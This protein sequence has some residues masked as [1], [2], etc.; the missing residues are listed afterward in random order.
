MATCVESINLGGSVESAEANNNYSFDVTDTK[1][2]LFL[3]SLDSDQ[4]VYIRP[5]IISTL[6]TNAVVFISIIKKSDASTIR[7]T[8]ITGETI[9]STDLQEGSYYICFRTLFGS[10]VVGSS[11]DYVKFKREVE[12]SAKFYTGENGSFDL[13]RK[14]P[15]FACTRPLKYTL[16][17]GSLP[18]GLVMDTSGRI[19]GTLPLIDKENLKDFPSYSLYHGDGIFYTPI[20]VR[21]EFLVKLE[22]LDNNT[23][24][25]YRKFCIMIVNDWDLTTPILEMSEMDY[26]GGEVEYDTGYTNLPKNLC[27]PCETKGKKGDVRYIYDNNGYLVNVEKIMDTPEFKNSLYTWQV[28]EFG[29]ITSGDYTSKTELVN[30]IESLRYVIDEFEL[31]GDDFDFD[32][33]IVLPENYRIHRNESLLIP[34]DVPTSKAREWVM[35]NLNDIIEDGYGEDILTGYINKDDNVKVEIVSRG[36]D[37][38]LDLSF[39][40]DNESDISVQYDMQREL[41]L[42]KEPM[43]VKTDFLP[44]ELTAVISYESYN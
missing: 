7:N 38:Y 1:N 36:T 34:S 40:D 23:K 35:I 16:I 8:K 37:N 2:K 21:Y 42:A 12:I 11:F 25:V 5:K 28:N 41:I 15:V 13:Q 19:H 14:L 4:T 6:T 10:H 18:S 22:L 33:P 30:N 9:I 3:L 26:D 20:G 43:Y 44:T 39:V 27:P 32:E 17:S 31:G 24:F 29:N